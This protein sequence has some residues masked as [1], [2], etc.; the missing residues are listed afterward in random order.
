MPTDRER[1]DFM[2]GLTDKAEYTGKVILRISTFGCG[3]RL[4]E[5]S[6]DEAVFSVRAAIDE[7]MAA[8]KP[9]QPDP[10]PSADVVCR[11]CG[12]NHFDF[13]CKER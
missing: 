5:T 11:R 10:S 2:Q 7:F 6:R 1:L 13:E 3:W 8:N 12:G 4:H 9:N